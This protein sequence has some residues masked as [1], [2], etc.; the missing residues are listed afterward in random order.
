MVIIYKANYLSNKLFMFKFFKEWYESHLT[1]PNQV[2][3]ALI[4]LS[5]TLITYILLSTV[6]P[7]LVAVILAYM[8]D[9]LVVTLADK[10]KAKRSSCV[11]FVYSSFVIVS[12]AT[13]LILIPLMLNQIT[14]FIKSLPSM[15][16]RGKELIYSSS[17]SNSL[18]SPEQSSSIISAINTEISS[19]GSSIISYSLSSAGSVIETA[20]Y[21]LIVPIIIFFL[22]YDKVQI[23]TWFQK[24]FPEKLDLSRKAYAELDLKIGNYIRCKL[25]EIIIVWVSSTI[26]FAILGLNY[27]LLLG[28]LCGISVIIP[29]VGA[30]A[31]TI[32]IIVVSYFQWGTSSEFWYVLIAHILIQIIDG[33]VVVPIL[34]SDAVNLHPLAILIA[35]LF[36][37]TIWGIWGVFFAIPLAVLFNTLLNIWPRNELP[38]E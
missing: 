25:I 5:I 11:L 9:G 21:F 14:L 33:N 28:F 35:I 34:F 32:P 31:V 7:I 38:N 16:E 27:S 24:F 19:I 6:V 30:I 29:Y 2:A 15:L 18:I 3:L 20:V 36:F 4:I 1:D 8:L 26:L 37:G 12:L 17:D 10:Y 23:N 22:L 13:I